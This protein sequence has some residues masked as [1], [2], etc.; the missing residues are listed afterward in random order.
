MSTWPAQPAKPWM[1]PSRGDDVGAGPQHQVVRVAEH[2]LG[3]EVLEV[4]RRQRACT[5]PRVPTGMKHG[6]RERAPGGG[7]GAG[8]GGAV[9]GVDGDH[10]DDVDD[11]DDVMV[12]RATSMA[13][14]K[15]RKR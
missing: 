5:A 11:V 9:G 2:D 6:V 12:R 10:G 7:D 8:A 3:A 13:S 15:D 14:P 1:P 4:V